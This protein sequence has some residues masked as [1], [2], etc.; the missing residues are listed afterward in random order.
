LQPEC[1][2]AAYHAMARA[3]VFRVIGF[4]FLAFAAISIYRGEYAVGRLGELVIERVRVFRQK[5]AFSLM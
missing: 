1:R 5:P 4:G 2:V 3:T